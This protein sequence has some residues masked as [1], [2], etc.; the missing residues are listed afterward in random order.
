ML[1]RHTRTSGH[2]IDGPVPSRLIPLGKMNDC[3]G[4]EQRC[5]VHF[6]YTVDETMAVDEVVMKELCGLE[7]D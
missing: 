1:D 6:T 7:M 5:P 4:D 3:K 2:S